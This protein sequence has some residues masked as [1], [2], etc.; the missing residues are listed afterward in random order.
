M[1]TARSAR[2]VKRTLSETRES[3]RVRTAPDPRPSSGEALQTLIGEL[4]SPR[5][6]GPGKTYSGAPAEAEPRPPPPP[7]SEDWSPS[8]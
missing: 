2:S 7:A 5:D 4:A 3:L 1:A 8:Y 6:R